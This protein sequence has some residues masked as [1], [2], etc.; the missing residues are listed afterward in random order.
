MK[1]EKN[2]MSRQI[3]TMQQLTDSRLLYDKK[4]PKFGYILILTVLMLLAV[5]VIWSMKAP[6]TYIIHASGVVESSN[7]NYVMSPYTG[8]IS[9]I[10]IKEGSLV[11]KGDVLFVIESTEMNLQMIQLKEQKVNYE[12]KIS[13]YEKLVASI[14]DDKNYFNIAKKEDTLYYSQFEAYKSQVAQNQVDVSTY[15]AYGYTEEQIENQLKT[16]QAKITEIYYSAISTAEMSIAEAQSQIDAIDAQISALKEGQGEY[17]IAANESGVIHMMSDYD[18]G[19]VVQASS[20]IASIASQQDDYSIIAYVEPSDMARTQI[21][22]RVDIAVAG[23]TQSIYGTISG[24]V[25]AVD[26]DITTSQNSE[27][28]QSTSYFKIYIKPDMNYMI[29][30]EGNRA[31]LSNGMA[32]EARIQYDEV[33]YFDYVMEALGVLTR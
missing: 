3:K 29:S 14:K 4:L 31:V 27:N 17:S 7:K 18:E 11:Q 20:P 13:Q 15:K 25:T 19:M 24:E 33:T 23:L 26:S 30:K 2:I 8:K 9:E 12:T 10:Y 16:N 5:V 6:K 28:G 21:G 32:V 22:D 1:K